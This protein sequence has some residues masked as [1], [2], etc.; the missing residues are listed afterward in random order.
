MRARVAT[1]RLSAVLVRREGSDD[2]EAVR[3]VVGAAFDRATRD[4]GTGG[5]DV[6]GSGTGGPG[7]PGAGSVDAPVEVTLL[8]RL[9]ADVGWLPRFSLV[10]Q[11]P[12]DPAVIG[13]VVCTRGRVGDRP[14]LG[15]GPLAVAP[16]EQYRGVGSAL[17]HAALGAA[18]ASGE[19]LV[20][21]LGEPA[22][23][24]RFGFRPAS[25][26]GVTAPD[27]AWGEYF[28]VRSFRPAAPVGRFAYAAPFAEL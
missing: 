15:L 3:A 13:H 12:D 16:A 23:Y 4:P 17:M 27:P 20:A 1:V 6:P 19:S 9:R 28:Q 10:A 18:E 8:D 26:H 2:V 21:V 7:G 5:S 14:A 11:R 22:Y 24:G 25:E